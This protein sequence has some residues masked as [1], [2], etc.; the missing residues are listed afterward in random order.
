MRTELLNLVYV[1]VGGFIG[2]I[3]RYLVSGAVYQLFP[4]SYFPIGTAVVNITGCLLIGLL[5]GLTELRQ[6]LNP[7][8]R[9]FLLIGLLGGFT[10]FS[11][12]GYETVAS[13]RAGEFVPALANV[14][15]QVIVGLSAVWLG[16]NVTR[17]F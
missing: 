16:Y 8:M 11:T 3:G 17:Y 12:F 14:L 13:L 7:E 2:S 15:I 5:S 4:N 6:L 9:I 10:T 1:G